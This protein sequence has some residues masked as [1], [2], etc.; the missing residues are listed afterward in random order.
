MNTPHTS[1]TMSSTLKNVY[2][3]GAPNTNLSMD[4]REMACVIL[5]LVG[6]KNSLIS[7]YV[8]VEGSI[9]RDAL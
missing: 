2:T 6:F 9:L 5:I 8:V 7:Q 3:E 1:S 4:A